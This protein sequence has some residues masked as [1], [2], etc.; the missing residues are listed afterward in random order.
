[1]NT[2]LKGCKKLSIPEMWTESVLFQI[3]Y[4]PL[5][6]SFIPSLKSPD[7]SNKLKSLGMGI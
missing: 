1:L 6:L 7:S 5:S 3:I 4:T 2:Y